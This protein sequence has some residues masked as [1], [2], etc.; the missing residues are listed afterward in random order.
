MIVRFERIV[1][2]YAR[3][4]L[5]PELKFL[6]NIADIR[7][8]KRLIGAGG[9][10]DI[11][12]MSIGIKFI[13]QFYNFTAHF[14]NILVLPATRECRKQLKCDRWYRTYVELVARKCSTLSHGLSARAIN[15]LS[16]NF[17]WDIVRSL[18]HHL[19]YLQGLQSNLRLGHPWESSTWAWSIAW[20][21]HHFSLVW[22]LFWWW[23]GEE[24]KN[25]IYKHLEYIKVASSALHRPYRRIS[26][27]LPPAHM[28]TTTSHLSAPLNIVRRRDTHSTLYWWNIFHKQDKW[29]RRRV[30]RAMQRSI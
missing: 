29:H 13:H 11:Q 7:H 26:L 12:S 19:Q 4:Q 18:S 17:C 25:I 28:S 16:L 14:F 6:H 2:L 27:L 10:D 5:L 15:P 3:H 20:N 9:R 1:G 8:E 23:C 30:K 22:C 24:W 21:H